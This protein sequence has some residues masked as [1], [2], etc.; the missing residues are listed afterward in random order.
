MTNK[1]MAGVI[2]C[3]GESRR[4]GS[5]KALLELDG[6]PLVLR[7][8]R[9]L[10]SVADPVLIAPGTPGRFG[11]LGH[12]E[13]EDVRAGT[14]PIGGLVAALDASPHELMAALA[15]DM[16]F[17]SPAVFRLLADQHAYEDAVVPMT[18]TGLQP[19]HAVYSRTSLPA[20]RRALDQGRLAL[21]AALEG[22][23]IRAIEE[24]DWRSVDPTG[25]FALNVNGP[26]DL[27]LIPRVRPMGRSPSI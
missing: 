1:D 7:A 10:A 24:A 20:L 17:A 15:V 3:G 9:R 8:A 4:M 6:E 14:G 22:L 5:P 18:A 27:S 25:S 2:L 21:R 13:V 23:Q 12:A 11:D 16:P 19:L 26:D